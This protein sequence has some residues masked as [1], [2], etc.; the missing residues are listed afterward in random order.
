M[1]SNNISLHCAV[2]TDLHYARTPNVQIPSRR[3]ELALQLLREAFDFYETRNPDLVLIAGDCLNDPRDPEAAALLGELDHLFR[4]IRFPV[5]LVPGNHDP[6]PERFY[7][8]L[9]RTPEPIDLKGFRIVPFPNDPETAGYN[10]IRTPAGLKKMQ[11]AAKGFN[12][13]LIALQHVPLYPP[14]LDKA[15]YRYENAQEIIRCMENCH[16]V[17]SVSGHQHEGV[18][19]EEYHGIHFLTAPALA[20]AP[21]QTMEIEINTENKLKVQINRHGKS[22]MHIQD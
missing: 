12:G 9:K 16:Y 15:R 13:Q 18:P 14:V 7:R 5:I 3:G 1:N 4:S 6:A 22:L 20:E 11:D 10:A 8:Y 17:L 19:A 21:F 2:I